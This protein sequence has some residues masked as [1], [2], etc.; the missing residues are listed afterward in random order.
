MNENNSNA[1]AWFDV[2]VWAPA[3]KSIVRA[4]PAAISNLLASERAQGTAWFAMGS[5]ASQGANVILAILLGRILGVTSFGELAFIQ[6]TVL[7][8]AIVGD[9][10]VG[11]AAT[12]FVAQWWRSDTEKAGRIISLCYV[13]TGIMAV[14][15]VMFLVVSNWLFPRLVD[16]PNQIPHVAILTGIL[17]MTEMANRVQVSA[18]LGLE[19]FRAAC[20]VYMVR[21]VLV[22]PVVVCA[23]W[24]GGLPAA[25]LGF[26]ACASAATARAQWSLRQACRTRS[27]PLG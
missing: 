20:G 14:A 2:S 5:A 1:L 16:L 15:L 3:K 27:I 7:T 11:L 6:T 8:R 9:V 13:L 22:L 25:I 10:G 24:Y 17:L 23:G 4:L 18:L 26:I 19:E 21:G 12:K